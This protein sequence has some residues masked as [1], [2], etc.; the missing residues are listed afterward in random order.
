[1]V[2][3]LS[4]NKIDTFI[5]NYPQLV[6]DKEDFSKRKRSKN[7]VPFHERCSAKRASGERCTRRRKENSEYC[8]THMK[9]QPHGISKTN[10]KEITNHT[11]TLRTQDIKGIMYYIDDFNNVYKSEDI[12]KDCKMPR[13][14]A[15]YSVDNNGNYSIPEFI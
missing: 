9:G 1:M 11:I 3:D 7:V 8:G 13:I 6:F 5:Q 10:E 12:I 2:L 15:K 4:K 14:I